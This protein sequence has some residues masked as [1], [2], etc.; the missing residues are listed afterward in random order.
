MPFIYLVFG[1]AFGFLLNRAGATE[2]DYYAQLFLFQDMQLLHVIGSAVFVGAL[3]LFI[4][5]RNGCRSLITKQPIKFESR[6]YR[7]GFVLGS[8]MFGMGWGASG[9]CPGSVLAMLGEGKLATLPTIAG[10]VI[11]TWLYGL[12]YETIKKKEH[13]LLCCVLPKHK[14]FSSKKFFI[15]LFERATRSHMKNVI[16]PR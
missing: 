8:L 11:G 12:G 10:I 3:G 15:R 14:W 4:L 1:I 9:S 2:Y 5:K 16:D 7:R 6:P 13:P